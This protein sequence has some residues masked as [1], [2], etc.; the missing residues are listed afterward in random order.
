MG[1]TSAAWAGF[2]NGVLAHSL[3]YDDMHLPLILHP[4]A[5]VVP[6]ALAAA[7]RPGAT[8]EQLLRAVAAGLEVCVRL[9][10]AGYDRQSGNSTFFEHG[11][12]A[13]SI[14]GAIGESSAAASLRPGATAETVADA[15]AISVSMASGVIEANDSRR[16]SRAAHLAVGTP[17]VRTIDEPLEVNQRRETGYQAQFSGP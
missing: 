14:C 11:Q 6:A 1:R 13:T 3:D 4:S 8:G 9:G 12:H 16:T 7:E 15:M 2:N 17:T 10:M 5:S